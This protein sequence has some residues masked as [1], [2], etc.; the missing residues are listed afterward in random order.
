[1]AIRFSTEHFSFD[2]FSFLL[3][4]KAL[5]V[6]FIVTDVIEH[7]RLLRHC[8]PFQEEA[9]HQHPC[10]CIIEIYLHRPSWPAYP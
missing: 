6:A 10:T 7:L 4:I 1:M 2:H 9:P 3:F 8:Q 5:T